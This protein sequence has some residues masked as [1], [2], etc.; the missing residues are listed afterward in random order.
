MEQY[1]ELYAHSLH[2]D[3]KT[4]LEI[5]SY[6]RKSY[7]YQL[8][9]SEKF[10]MVVK[11]N[12]MENEHSREKLQNGIIPDIK[13]YLVGNVSVGIDLSSGEFHVECE[14][15]KNAIPIYDDLFVYRGL[16]ENDLKNFVIVGQYIE[17]TQ[18]I[19]L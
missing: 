17:L 6:F 1:F 9:E 12:I 7:S 4:G 2:T 19:A 15:I 13:T 5:D 8:F 18:N 14:E 3:R 16:D 11:E 10:Q